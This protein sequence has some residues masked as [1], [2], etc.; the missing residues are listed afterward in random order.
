MQMKQ[1]VVE[2]ISGNEHSLVI[3]KK[4]MDTWLSCPLARICWKV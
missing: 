3:N 1:F 4:E 2:A